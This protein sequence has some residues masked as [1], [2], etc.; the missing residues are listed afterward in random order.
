MRSR[1]WPGLQSSE[2]LTGAIG[3]AVKTASTHTAVGRRPQFL[4]TGS[5]PIELLKHPQ[6]MVAGF[7]QSE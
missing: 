2:A 3:S 6:D 1:F 7:P 4:S 5:F